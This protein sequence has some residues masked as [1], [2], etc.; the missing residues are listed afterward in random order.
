MT[1]EPPREILLFPL[2]TVLF[3]DGVLP[4]RVFEQ[5]YIELTKTCLR[6]DVPFG[7]CLIREGGEV[8]TAAVP[9]P[10]GCLARITQWDMP[11]MGLFHLLT[12][13]ERRFRI[14]NTRVDPGQLL[15]AE[16]ELL[17]IE[18]GA[19]EP[20]AQCAEILKAII[21]K[22][23]A[24]NFPDPLKLDD[25]A[26]VSYRLAEILPLEPREK[27]ELLEMPG[28]AER[29]LRLRELLARAGLGA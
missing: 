5:R 26:W 25:A 29:F 3:P 2:N 14:R 24:D 27:Q 20:D 22:I 21:A 9:A 19:A 4:L 16:V 1:A 12:R 10:V 6:D 23:G 28:V 18:T 15:S 13:G 17:P 11:R 7:V 8:G